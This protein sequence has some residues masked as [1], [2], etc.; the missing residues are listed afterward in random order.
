[1]PLGNRRQRLDFRHSVGYEGLLSAGVGSDPSKY[2]SG[3]C[4]K[5]DNAYVNRLN[6]RVRLQLEA[7]FLNTSRNWTTFESTGFVVLG[8]RGDGGSGHHHEQ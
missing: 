5:L 7:H 3:I 1:M 6:L 4:I 2:D 8:F